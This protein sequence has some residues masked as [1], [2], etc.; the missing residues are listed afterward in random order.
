METARRILE[1]MF[2]TAWS[3]G[4]FEGSEAFAIHKLA[5]QVPMLREIASTSDIDLAAK[6]RLAASGI[7][8][9]VR[10]VAHAIP[11][12]AHR[13]LAFQCCAKSAER[14]DAFRA[15]RRRCC[16]SSAR[17]GDSPA[18]TSSGSWSSPRTP[19]GRALRPPCSGQSR[20]RCRRNLAAAREPHIRGLS[21]R[22]HF[23]LRHAFFQFDAAQEF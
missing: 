4:R 9:C 23:P 5:A 19:D 3:D 12:A 22:L 21:I 17:R 8:A 6:E 7:E 1:L 13:E 2:L 15:R 16:R 18:P 14:T 20:I 10:E 11:V